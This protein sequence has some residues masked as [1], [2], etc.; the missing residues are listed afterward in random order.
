[1]TPLVLQVDDVAADQ[2]DQRGVDAG[3]RLVEE[4][5]LRLGHDGARDLEQLLLP[6]GELARARV[7]VLVQAVDVEHVQR[8]LRVLALLHAERGPG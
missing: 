2:F 4:Q 3:H 8:A 1:M 7:A 6:A 5:D